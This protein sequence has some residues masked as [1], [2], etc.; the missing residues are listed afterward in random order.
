MTAYTPHNPWLVWVLLGIGIEIF[1]AGL[2]LNRLLARISHVV[3]AWGLAAANIIGIERFMCE[4]PPGVRMTAL[5]IVMLGSMK[6]VVLAS[7]RLDGGPSLPTG[8]WC[9]FLCGW[10]G[11]QP[12]IFAKPLRPNRKLSSTLALR[13]F[14][15]VLFGSA[16]LLLAKSMAASTDDLPYGTISATIASFLLLTGISLVTHFGLFNL[17]AAGWQAVGLN[18]QPLFRAPLASTSLSEFWSRRWNLAFSEMTVIAV[19]RPCQPVLGTAVALWAGFA[20]SGLLH[21]MAITVPVKTGYGGPF[22]YFLLH[23]LLVLLERRFDL[24]RRFGVWYR[25]W[26]VLCVVGPLPWLF[27]TDFL[28]E[29]VWPLVGVVQSPA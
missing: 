12:A 8:R 25:A 20:F 29:I 28:R 9:C 17:L 27:T 11:M 13:G 1:L 14:T 4:E 22:G 26:I 16:F 10:P 23:G 21:E 24:P 15:R 2:V 18:C 5:I 19:F 7:Y 6:L 3:L